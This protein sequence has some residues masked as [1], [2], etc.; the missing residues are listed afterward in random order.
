MPAGGVGEPGIRTTA[1]DAGSASSG[2]EVGAGAGAIGAFVAA[3]QALPEVEEVQEEAIQGFDSGQK[4]EV[5][6][7]AEALAVEA[8]KSGIQLQPQVSSASAW[9]TD[10]GKLQFSRSPVLDLCSRVD[11]A[12]SSLNKFLRGDNEICQFFFG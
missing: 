12:K 2:G 11:D 3:M 5:T 4:Q 8:G 10:Y 1:G 7:A 6:D 9:C